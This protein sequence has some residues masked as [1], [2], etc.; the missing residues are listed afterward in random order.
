[1]PPSEKVVDD[2][3]Q[4]RSFPDAHQIATNRSLPE[5]EVTLCSHERGLPAF[6]T[7]W[8]HPL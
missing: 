8:T 6:T 3:F 7:E 2:R 5:E 4:V 1:M